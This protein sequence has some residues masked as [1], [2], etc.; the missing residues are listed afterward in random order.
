MLQLVAKN[1][2]T[3][4]CYWLGEIVECD[5]TTSTI[6][7]KDCRHIFEFTLMMQVHFYIKLLNISTSVGISSFK[8]GIVG[9]EMAMTCPIQTLNDTNI[10][11][12]SWYKLGNSTNQK[13]VVIEANNSVIDS[14]VTSSNQ[15]RVNRNTHEDGT[16]TLRGLHLNDTGIY[17]CQLDAKNHTEL[18]FIKLIVNGKLMETKNYIT[19]F[20]PKVIA[21]LCAVTWH[22]TW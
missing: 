11:E 22:C 19:H 6:F 4:I 2:E 13:V 18:R 9:G 10:G 17:E 12:W 3:G 15:S 5:M 20:R 1:N 7:S 21:T 14:N 16:L 8:Q